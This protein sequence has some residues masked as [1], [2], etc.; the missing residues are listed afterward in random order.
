[1]TDSTSVLY[2]DHLQEL[3][4]RTDR[5][6]ANAKLT[7]V[8][9]YSGAPHDQFLDDRP[10][11]YCVNPHFK[12]WVPLLN[13]PHSWVIYTRGAKPTLIFLQPADYWHQPPEAP[14]GYWTDSFDIHVIR[15]PA[16]A[17][18]FMP[19]GRKCAFIGEW[20]DEF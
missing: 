2:L 10:Y 6:L 14:R 16:E 1:M 8:A 17:R 7:S 3:V 4:K 18:A 5:A 11:T 9:L 12:A 19:A 20:S 13:A 15:E